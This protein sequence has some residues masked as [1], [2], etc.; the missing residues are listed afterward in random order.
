MGGRGTS[1]AATT[2]GEGAAAELVV[3]FVTA[4]YCGAGLMPFGA[5]LVFGGM[6]ALLPV[7]AAAGK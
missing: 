5:A 7:T 4:G 1:S 3:P 6:L 2:C